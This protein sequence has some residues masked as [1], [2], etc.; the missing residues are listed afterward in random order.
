MQL[1]LSKA[2]FDAFG[3]ACR[4]H[5]AARQGHASSSSIRAA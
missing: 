1:P 3:D 5:L 2:M 4:K